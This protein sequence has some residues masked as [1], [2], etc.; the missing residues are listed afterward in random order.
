MQVG[1]VGCGNW[2]AKHV[3]VLSSLPQ[4]RQVVAIEPNPRRLDGVISSFPHA[5]AFQDLESA[6]PHVSALVIATPPPTHYELASTALRHGKH[7][8]VE[9]PMTQSTHEAVRLLN[10]ARRFN[11]VLMTGHTLLFN[12]AVDKLRSHLSDGNLGQIRSV[13]AAQFSL[14]RFSA[15]GADAVWDFAPHSISVFNHL[16]GCLPTSVSASNAHSSEQT[17]SVQVEL[18][19]GEIGASGFIHISRGG[20]KKIR[21][22]TVI[23]SEK[24]VVYDDLAANP[25]QMYRQASI[26]D[27]EM[28]IKHEPEFAFSKLEYAEPLVE[29]LRHFLATI[30]D[31]S[32][33]RSSGR[34]GMITV[35]I[36]EA[37]DR[38]RKDK[39][40]RDIFYPLD[41]HSEIFPIVDIKDCTVPRKQQ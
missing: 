39:R 38:S 33:P 22:F 12:P 37:I 10:E 36:I 5:Q 34:D 41:L 27:L 24:S 6:L 2:G 19:Y 30:K 21:T 17:E 7:V 13:H 40:E 20:T 28:G 35:A 9:K 16:I 14:E 23:G 31:R 1:V 11:C 18:R 8:L 4:V 3:R 15:H 29:E 26:H 25:L 32:A